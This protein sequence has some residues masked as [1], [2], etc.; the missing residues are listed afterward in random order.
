MK[1]APDGRLQF[2]I[3][4][5]EGDKDKFI[6][7]VRTEIQDRIS[8]KSTV[9]CLKITTHRNQS[10]T[11]WSV[12]DGVPY[13]Q[14]FIAYLRKRDYKDGSRVYEVD[15]A[16]TAEVMEIVTNELSKVI[17]DHQKT[18]S[19]IALTEILVREETCDQFLNTLLKGRTA[20]VIGAKGKA[21][22]VATLLNGMQEKLR[23][24]SASMATNLGDKITQLL[25]T[26]SK[27][28]AISSSIAIATKFLASASGKV[29]LSKL[30][31]VIGKSLA[32]L[33]T[34]LLAMPII[35]VALK[36]MI[37]GAI[38]GT[39]VKLV[40]A[41]LGVSV[42][43]AVWFVLAPLLIAF[44]VK[45]LI[46]FPKK[47]ATALSAAVCGA[48]EETY[49]KTV[50]DILTG[51]IVNFTSNEVIDEIASGLADDPEVAEE[52]AKLIE[53]ASGAAAA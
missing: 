43:T 3:K 16:L 35:Q 1:E 48:L 30:S 7:T 18:I 12:S 31:I 19:D 24:L 51:L 26:A 44:I 2:L 53:I 52:L 38:I 4:H 20:H 49:S 39:M 41:K 40:A 28:T 8:A 50:T 25:A 29:I 37:I 45:D 47:L 5:I 27:S 42:A 22:I 23:H 13:A 33:I 9:D 11:T 6:S 15:S 14:R 21:M 10:S 32:P 46:D 34:K 36:K 17:L